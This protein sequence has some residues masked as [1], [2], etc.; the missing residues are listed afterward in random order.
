KPGVAEV[1]FAVP[2]E[3]HGRGIATLLLEHLV[4]IARQHGVHAFTGETLAE[5]TAMLTVF[6][7]RKR[8]SLRGGTPACPLGHGPFLP[9]PTRKARRARWDTRP[10]TRPGAHGSE[11]R[12][13]N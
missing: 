13:P 6:A 12:S 5:N 2:D 7:H 4:S 1:A 8:I 10:P 11:A 9:T 3:M